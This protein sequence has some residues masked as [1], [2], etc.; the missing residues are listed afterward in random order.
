MLCCSDCSLVSQLLQTTLLLT[1][2]SGVNACAPPP[3]MTSL[4]IALHRRKYSFA[5]AAATNYWRPSKKSAV[6]PGWLGPAMLKMPA[7]YVTENSNMKWIVKIL[8]NLVVFAV[9]W[10]NLQLAKVKVRLVLVVY[11]RSWN[12]TI[13][14][15]GWRAVIGGWGA[16]VYSNSRE[17]LKKG[18][19]HHF[20]ICEKAL[21][22][23]DCLV[24]LINGEQ[25][26]RVAVACFLS[27]GKLL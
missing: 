26:S 25:V 27:V 14:A 13:K 10:I 23:P 4:S 6:E 7:I 19:R 5:A 9:P 18:F 3:L 22:N 15:T 8:I 2:V 11:D 16:A 20:F 17:A 21:S 12:G 24:M 1:V